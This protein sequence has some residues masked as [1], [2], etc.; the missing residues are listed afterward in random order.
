MRVIMKG[1]RL[2]IFLYTFLYFITY[3]FDS[4]VLTRVHAIIGL[5]M[6]CLAAI[7]LKLNHFKL[8][9]F[10]LLTG[11]T[12]MLSAE[13][14]IPKNFQSGLLQMSNIIGLLAVVPM[15]GW[16]LRSEPYIEDIIGLA[17][18]MLNTSRKFY[19]G[20]MLFTHINSYFLLFGVIPMMYQFINDI[21]KKEQGEAWEKFKGTA[22]L[23]AFAL[24]TLWVISIPSFAF[25]VEALNASL[26]KAILQGF[27]ITAAAMI[28]AIIFSYFEEKRYGVDLTAEIKSEMDTVLEQ[29]PNRKEQICKTLE[30]G[31]LFITLFGS[32][33]L[34]YEMLAVELMILIP[35]VIIIWSGI[36]FLVKKKPKKLLAEMNNYYVN[37]LSGQSYQFSV[38]ISAGVM[39]FSMNQTGIGEAIVNGIY[40]MQEVVPFINIL[41]FLPLI[42]VVLGFLGLGPLTVMVLVAGILESI[43]LP[44]P[45]ELVVL[46]VT[47][48]SAISILLSPLIMPVI[49]LSGTNGLSPFKNGIK[50]NYQYAIMLYVLVQVYVQWMVHV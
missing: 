47:S 1:L 38:L 39:I 50:F 44:Y 25:A 32:I 20:I 49:V 35:L 10:L 30:F 37:G 34:L 18:N 42:V 27:C 23:R 17:H 19:A 9:L 24:S 33:F 28:M 48:G 46:S 11:T 2:S 16:V 40:A 22:L 43:S 8:P 7:H 31:L 12:I 29:S 6:L 15:I 41:Y 26:S 3:F 45:P 21:L 14:F 36:Y 13:G 4:E 5:I